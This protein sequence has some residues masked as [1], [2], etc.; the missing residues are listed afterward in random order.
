MNVL[1]TYLTED[2][3]TLV[4]VAVFFNQVTVISVSLDASSDI[5]SSCDP[6]IMTGLPLR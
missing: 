1:T 5:I 4:V 3:P 6:F 2:W